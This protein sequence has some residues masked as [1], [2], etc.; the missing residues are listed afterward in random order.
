MK[1]LILEGRWELIIS[2]GLNVLKNLRFGRYLNEFLD[3]DK[4]VR[5][6]LSLIF[7]TSAASISH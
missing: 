3:G 1:G 5:T 2:K 7:I 4:N 6:H